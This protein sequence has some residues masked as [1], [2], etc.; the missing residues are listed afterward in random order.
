MLLHCFCGIGKKLAELIVSASRQ[1]QFHLDL[2]S[3]CGSSIFVLSISKVSET[4]DSL[5]CAV[6]GNHASAGRSFTKT[7]ARLKSRYLGIAEQI[8]IDF[9]TFAGPA[10]YSA[11]T[12]GQ[13]NL[14]RFI[15]VTIRLGTSCMHRLRIAR[16]TR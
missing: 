5:L 16:T 15:F 14:T 11:N 3:K 12:A 7:L 10:N 2:H 9:H 8:T 1:R 4:Q 6:L 13:G